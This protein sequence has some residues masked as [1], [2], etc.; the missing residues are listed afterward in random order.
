MVIRLLWVSLATAI[1]GALPYFVLCLITLHGPASE[2]GAPAVGAL[3]FAALAA[4]GLVVAFACLF[5]AGLR[6]R[7]RDQVVTQYLYGWPIGIAALLFLVIAVPS[8]MG[9]LLTFAAATVACAFCAMAGVGAAAFWLHWCYTGR[10]P[11]QPPE[12]TRGT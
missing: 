2:G 4:A 5:I 12:T 10:E 1:I 9:G 3:A 11:N 8:G 7:T 6:W